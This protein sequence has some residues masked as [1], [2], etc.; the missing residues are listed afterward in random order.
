VP[1]GISVP[2]GN[3]F[4]ILANFPQNRKGFLQKLNV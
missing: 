2:M 4:I 1:V 3:S